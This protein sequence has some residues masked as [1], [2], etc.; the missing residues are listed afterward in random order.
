MVQLHN[1]ET[2][3]LIGEISEAQLAF[4]INNLEEEDVDDVDYY[5]D[6][7]M[8]DLLAADG[9]DA[10]LVAMLRQALDENGEVEFYWERP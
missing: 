6:E 9:A 7:A 1:K 2:G 3:A 5:L 4:L 10:G 8:V